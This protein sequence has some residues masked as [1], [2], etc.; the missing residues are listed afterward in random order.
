MPPFV[1]FFVMRDFFDAIALGRN[2]SLSFSTLKFRS[3]VVRIE[4]FVS[5]HGIEAEAFD[6]IIH[7]DDFAALTRE[8]LEADQVPQSISQSQNLGRQSAFRATYG[9]MLSPPFAPLAFW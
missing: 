5:K 6:Q 1:S 9:L 7:A 2:D 8:K 3:Q 4:G